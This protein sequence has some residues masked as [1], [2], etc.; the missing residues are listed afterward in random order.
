MRRARFRA[1]PDGR[2]RAAAVSHTAMSAQP[3]PY[4][5]FQR[6]PR[7]PVQGD[8]PPIPAPDFSDPDRASVELSTHRTKL[9]THRTFLSEHRT[10]LSEHRT[11][12]SE[13]RTRLSEH[14]SD[15][16]TRRTEMSSRRTGMSFQ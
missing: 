10:G 3:S 12:L 11:D 9:S 5:D 2:T 7:D 6:D 14:R 8:L 15:L 4:A 16:S 13:K 1:L